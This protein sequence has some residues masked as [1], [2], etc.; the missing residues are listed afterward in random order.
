MRH[1]FGIYFWV[2]FSGLGGIVDVKGLDK[3]IRESRIRGVRGARIPVSGKLWV[4][5]REVPLLPKG[6]AVAPCRRVSQLGVRAARKIPTG[7]S[8]GRVCRPECSC[9]ASLR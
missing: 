3:A 1:D 4:L 2:S 5:F 9:R 8:I 7:I 6:V